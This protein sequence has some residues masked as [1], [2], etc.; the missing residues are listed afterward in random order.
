MAVRALLT[1]RLRARHGCELC[2]SVAGRRLALRWV[3]DDLYWDRVVDIRPDGEEE[4]F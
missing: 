3:T 1:S 2:R 4:V